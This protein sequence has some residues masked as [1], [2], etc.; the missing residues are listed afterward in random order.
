MK[1][2]TTKEKQS[3]EVDTSNNSSLDLDQFD[4]ENITD[5][6]LKK[7]FKYVDSLDKNTMYD[8][9]AYRVYSFI[10]TPEGASIL[11]FI[12]EPK[13]TF[14][15]NKSRLTTQQLKSINCQHPKERLTNN[16]IY[17]LLKK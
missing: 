1:K 9:Q 5:E 13:T 14:G 6:M 15:L 12:H 17:W 16:G 11:E 2:S 8:F 4:Y 3:V 7:Y 10:G